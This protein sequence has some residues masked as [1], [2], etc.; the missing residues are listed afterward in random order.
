[1]THD[2]REIQLEALTDA[3][4]PEFGYIWREPDG[5]AYVAIKNARREVLQE[6]INMIER[7]LDHE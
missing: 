1:M 5:I 2:P 7:K 4:H 6:V 3:L